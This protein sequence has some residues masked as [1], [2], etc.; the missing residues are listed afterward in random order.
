[1][2][3]RAACH[4]PGLSLPARKQLPKRKSE[5]VIEKQDTDGPGEAKKKRKEKAA[6]RSWRLGGH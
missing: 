2:G 4:H 1:M 6:G 5:D 3:G